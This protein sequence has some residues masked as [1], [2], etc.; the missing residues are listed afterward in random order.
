MDSELYREGHTL[1]PGN[2]GDTGQV[3][4]FPRNVECRK[5]VLRMLRVSLSTYCLITITAALQYVQLQ[6]C[7]IVCMQHGALH[8]GN[9]YNMELVA[10][11]RCGD[12][13]LLLLLLLIIKTVLTVP[14]SES[15]SAMHHPSPRLDGLYF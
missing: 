2:L 9:L 5:L 7:L 4:M 8:A 3:I 6:H 1:N 12:V 10:K 15:V 13:T 11:E 14:N